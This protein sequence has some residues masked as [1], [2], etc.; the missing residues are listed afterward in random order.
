MLIGILYLRLGF[1]K[2]TQ[3]VQKLPVIGVYRPSYRTFATVFWCF[4]GI[5]TEL[6]LP[7]YLATASII[8]VIMSPL[9][10][11]T[12]VRRW[13]GWSKTS[14]N[15]AFLEFM[16]H[17]IKTC[18]LQIL[19]SLWPRNA[20]WII[21]IVWL[22]RNLEIWMVKK[23]QHSTSSQWIRKGENDGCSIPWRFKVAIMSRLKAGLLMCFISP[24]P[25]WYHFKRF[26]CGLVSTPW[27]HFSNID[28][29]YPEIISAITDPHPEII[30]AG[31]LG[32]QNHFWNNA[33]V[34]HAL[35]PKK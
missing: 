19:Q 26:W 27:N 30:S 12:V 29:P 8:E 5:D 22:T 10:R 7:T 3:H 11:P 17:G 31:V 13:C 20:H 33:F 28:F 24:Q 9:I 32:A 25:P 14:A 1:Q 35:L 34:C 23:K 6:R 21:A 15:K 16:F 2:K 18:R 4:F